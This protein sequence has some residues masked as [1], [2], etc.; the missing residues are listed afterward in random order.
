MR[1]VLWIGAVL[2]GCQSKMDEATVKGVV[3]L[4]FKESNPTE[5]RYGWEISG[6]YQ[7][8]DGT[9]F[10][11][12]CLMDN[13]LAFPNHN[14]IGQISPDYKVQH[15][16]TGSSKKGYCLDMGGKLSYTI[17]SIEHVS[18]MGSMDIQN[19]HIRFELQDTTPWFSCLKEDITSRVVRVENRDGK[20][21][22]NPDDH[23]FFQEGNGCPNPV[24]KAEKRVPTAQP[25]SKPPKAPSL[26]EVKQLAQKFDDALFNREFEKAKGMISC[27]NLLENTKWGTC[28]LAEVLAIGPSTHGESRAEDADPWLESTVYDVA[29]FEKVTKDK[30]DPTLFHVMMT[31]RRN[32]QK[33]SLTV[34]WAN[35][36]WKLFALVSI[37][38]A[39]ITKI[40]LMND[41]HDAKNRDIY[42]Q[43][44]A[45]AKIDY[46][47]NSTELYYEK[48]E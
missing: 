8:F 17:D 4:A 12:D 16:I 10:E 6:K 41:L 42:E 27:V 43:R 35:G 34:Q 36:R 19:V 23:L 45:G 29:K 37:P 24:P 32:K 47:G 21:M 30:K 3:D 31:H 22:L 18:E 38:S 2:V 48:E 39:G 25:T 1:Q 20:P 9:A 11:K 46:K 14:K 5:G 13:G 44:L 28:S 26:D 15:Y 40:R 33:R 7:W